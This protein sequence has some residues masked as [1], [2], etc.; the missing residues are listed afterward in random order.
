MKNENLSFLDIKEVLL[1]CYNLEL[2]HIEEVKHS[3]TNCY[4]ITCSEGSK[5]FIKIFDESKNISKIEQ[6]YDLLIY[7]KIKDS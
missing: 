4:I 1:Y 6:E 2:E 3:S 5:Y 7:L